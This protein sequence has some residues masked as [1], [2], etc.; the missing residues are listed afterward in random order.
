MNER[1]QVNTLIF[2]IMNKNELILYVV[3]IC[4]IFLFAIALL[5]LK[6]DNYA[7]V[8]LASSFIVVIVSMFFC[9]ITSCWRLN[10]VM[11][12]IAEDNKLRDSRIEKLNEWQEDACKY[13]SKLEKPSD[14][15]SHED[16]LRK[17]SEVKR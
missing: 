5:F 8:A 17:S 15:D 7:I 11:K 10:D 2:L 12:Q 4:V 14:P 1:E 3:T 6:V 13:F 9:S 16:R